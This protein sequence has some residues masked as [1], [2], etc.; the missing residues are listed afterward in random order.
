MFKKII[1]LLIITN[2]LFTPL[3]YNLKGLN[4][5]GFSVTNFWNSNLN[6]KL[7]EGYTFIQE[8]DGQIVFSITLSFLLILIYFLFRK[9]LTK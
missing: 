4:V 2:T 8:I 7:P 3:Y 6:E 1:I 5:F 9:N